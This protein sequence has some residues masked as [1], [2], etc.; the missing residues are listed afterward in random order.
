MEAGKSKTK[1]PV[2]LLLGV[3]C[4]LCFKI[5]PCCCVQVVEKQKCQT[6]CD[7]SSIKAFVPFK[8]EERS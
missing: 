6:L 4:S 8:R 7:A 5:A 2:D 3:G 1:M